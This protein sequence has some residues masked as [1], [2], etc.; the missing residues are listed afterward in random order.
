MV[1]A[2]VGKYRVVVEITRRALPP[3]PLCNCTDERATLSNSLTLTYRAI[4]P[5]EQR[6]TFVERKVKAQLISDKVRS[7]KSVNSEAVLK[8]IEENPASNSQRVSSEQQISRVQ[9]CWST[10]IP[11]KKCPELLNCD[12]RYRNISSLFFV[13]ALPTIS[14]RPRGSPLV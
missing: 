9:C 3:P 8:G 4:T 6:K 14:G 2:V 1:A 12:S 11:Q 7:A 13:W 10:S 5:P